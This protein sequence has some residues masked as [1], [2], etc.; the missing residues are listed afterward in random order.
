[1]DCCI[2]P[3]SIGIW[4][5]YVRTPIYFPPRIKY[6]W[7]DGTGNYTIEGDNYLISEQLILDPNSYY[8]FTFRNLQRQGVCGHPDLLDYNYKEEVMR[9]SNWSFMIESP[10]PAYQ[11]GQIKGYYSQI[12]IK[13]PDGS[14]FHPTGYYGDLLI[15]SGCYPDYGNFSYYSISRSLPQLINVVLIDGVPS[16]KQYNLKIFLNNQKVYDQTKNSQPTAEQLPEGCLQTEQKTY[17]RDYQNYKSEDYCQ[18]VIQGNQTTLFVFSKQ[19][20]QGF[21]PL[22]LA[23]SS[24]PEQCSLAPIFDI[25]CKPCKSCPEGS[26]QVVCGDQVCCFNVDGIAVDS[27]P[28]EELCL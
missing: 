19:L 28:L 18:Q 3:P 27:F 6:N 26:C 4:K 21:A 5:I 11:D 7:N 14:I 13:R 8:R 20:N 9:G 24:S 15:T 23:Y 16:Q 17:V 2:S 12:R 1:M 10:Q 25:E 22:V